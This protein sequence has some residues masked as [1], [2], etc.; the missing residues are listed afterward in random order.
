MDYRIRLGAQGVDTTGMRG[1]GAAESQAPTFAERVK[2]R[3]RSW[4]P[5]GLAAM[6]ELLSWR[7]TGRMEEMRRHLRD[8]LSNANSWLDLKPEIATRAIDQVSSSTN[9][10]TL[11]ATTPIAGH[12]TTASGGMSALMNNI[13]GGGLATAS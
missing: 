4:G 11:T 2:G 8:W 1:L 12:G 5:S 6:M 7:N 9:S 13:I 10:G 3:G